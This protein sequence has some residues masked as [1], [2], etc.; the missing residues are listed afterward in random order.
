LGAVSTVIT[1]AA[2]PSSAADKMKSSNNPA[3]V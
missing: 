1:Q 2:A 3:M